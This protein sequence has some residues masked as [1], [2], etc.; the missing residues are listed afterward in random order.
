MDESRHGGRFNIAGVEWWRRTKTGDW[1]LYLLET[2]RYARTFVS[3]K[4]L[5]VPVCVVL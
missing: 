1:K 2:A 4:T 3:T 5:H